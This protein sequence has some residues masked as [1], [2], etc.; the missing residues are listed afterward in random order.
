IGRDAQA[1]SLAAQR[2]RVAPAGGLGD[3][4]PTDAVAALEVHRREPDRATVERLWVA[5][6]WNPRDV[7]LRAA[8]IPALPAAHPRRA[9]I[10]GELV[11]LAGGADR[12]LGRAAAA[13]LR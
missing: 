13:V 4:D 2:A 7:E 5:S 1:H 10:S 11:D 8:L 9:V 3:R 6:R 12:A